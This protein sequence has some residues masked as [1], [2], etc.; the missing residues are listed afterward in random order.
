MKLGDMLLNTCDWIWK[1]T[2]LNFL[3]VIFM[4]LGGVIFGIMPSTIAVF[5]ILRKWI[6][7]ESEIPIFKTFINVYKKEFINTNKCGVVYL[8]IFAFL[9]FDLTVLYNIE[10]TYSTVLYVLVMAVVFFSSMA[11]IY[12]F[13]IYV[14]F[15]SSNKEYIKNSFI[16]ALTSPLQTVIIIVGFIVLYH[17]IKI[18][19]GL[20][21]FFTIVVPGYWIMHILY[22]KFLKLQM[23]F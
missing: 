19:A 14:H 12:F 5:Y 13:P 20:L 4:L 11:F 8:V 2:R 1:F 18:N 16:L 21:M 6:Q 15:K 7:G 17:F 9:A 3:W 23:T 10:A 22:K